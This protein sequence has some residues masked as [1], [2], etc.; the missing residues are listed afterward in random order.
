MHCE[1]KFHDT[2]GEETML[3]KINS[4]KYGNILYQETSQGKVP[5]NKL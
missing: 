3:G 5:M 1:K 4:D 2:L